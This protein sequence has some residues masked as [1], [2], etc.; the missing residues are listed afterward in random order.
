MKDAY[1]VLSVRY[2]RLSAR[3]TLCLRG[4][5]YGPV[6]VSL[7]VCLSV[8]SRHC[9]ETNGRIEL[10]MTWRLLSTYPTQCCEEIRVFLK[11]G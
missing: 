7:S 9:V 2:Y 1:N 6:S 11:Y 5:S 8:R 3:T 4:I 10:V